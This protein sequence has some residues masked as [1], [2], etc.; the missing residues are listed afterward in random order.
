MTFLRTRSYT[1]IKGRG[2]DSTFYSPCTPSTICVLT[3]YFHCYSGPLPEGWEQA[4]TADGEVYYIDHINKTTTWV[5][6]RLGS[7]LS[8]LCLLNWQFLFVNEKPFFPMST[9][10]CCCLAT[11]I[12]KIAVL[13]SSFP[14]I[15]H[16]W[17]VWLQCKY[18]LDCQKVCRMTLMLQPRRWTLAFLAW[19]CSKGRKRKGSD[20][21]KA[22]LHKSHHRSELDWIVSADSLKIKLVEKSSVMPPISFQKSRFEAPTGKASFW[23][24]GCHCVL[25]C[26]VGGRRKEPDA[27]WDGPWQKH[28]DACPIAGCEDQS[29]KPRTNT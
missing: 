25:L 10:T 23:V 19:H 26:I 6:P 22:S 8:N 4:A 24:W 5:D 11:R 18:L 28:A 21:S 14:H 2:P 29:I 16:C 12:R 3:V 15:C 7:A 9:L 13:S 1:D 17:N 20:A 27:W